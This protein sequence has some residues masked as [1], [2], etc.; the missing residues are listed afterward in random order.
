MTRNGFRKA[1]LR[2]LPKGVFLAFS[3]QHAAVPAKM[4]EEPLDL[5]SDDD[6][7][8]LGVERQGA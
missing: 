1:R 2:V 8:L 4:A 5:S 7:F 6:E 3:T